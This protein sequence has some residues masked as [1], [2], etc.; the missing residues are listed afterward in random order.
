MEEK[1]V[2]LALTSTVGR[3]FIYFF[4]WNWEWLSGLIF[5]LAAFQIVKQLKSRLAELWAQ[6]GRAS[7]WAARV[8]SAHGPTATWRI[9]LRGWQGSLQ[10]CVV[11]KQTERGILGRKIWKMQH[12]VTINL[13]CSDC[14]HFMLF[15][16]GLWVSHRREQGMV[17]RW[18]HKGTS[19]WSEADVFIAPNGLLHKAQV[20]SAPSHLTDKYMNV[21]E[22]QTV[23]H[24]GTDNKL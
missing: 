3:F 1:W 7:P 8:C 10:F 17:G 19:T 2:K 23:L 4:A 15:L 6:D 18:E 13:S 12:Y 20:S 16:L 14:E 11:I 24:R 21:I 5:V 9:S 22:K